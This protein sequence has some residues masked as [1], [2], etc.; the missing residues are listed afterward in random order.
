MGFYWMAY[1]DGMWNVQ[2]AIYRPTWNYCHYLNWEVYISDL[3]QRLGQLNGKIR[4][5]M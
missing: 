5:R 2:N 4:K 3:M 1:L